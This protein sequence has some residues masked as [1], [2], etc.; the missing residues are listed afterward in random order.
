[1]SDTQPELSIIIVNWNGGQSL[2][3]CVQSVV[4][5][6]LE[7]TFD[8][9]V[10][11]N[12]SEDDSITQLLSSGKEL[13][14]R[15]I[16]NEE[17]RGFGAACNQGFAVTSSPYVFLLNPDAEV[18]PTSIG[19][20]LESLKKSPGVGAVG[21]R[22]L[23]SDGSVQASVF[24][25]PPNALHT[26]LWQLKLY[27]LL[28]KR[29]RGEL[30]LGRHWKH[31]RKR[32]VPMLT[33]AAIMIRREVIDQVGGFNEEF[34]MYGEDNEWCW[35]IKKAG[36]ELLFEPQAVVRHQG[37]QS[38]ARRWTPEEKLRVQLEAGFKFEQAA[39]SRRK[40]IANRL[41]NYLVVSTQVWFRELINER[42]PTLELVK[43]IQREL[44]QRSLKK[45]STT[46]R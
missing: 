38:A 40:L 14:L 37:G 24:V 2:V 34:H 39:L 31:N 35:R 19:T 32:R 11:D 3:E 33:G 26:V 10:V 27:H 4:D 46:S 43:E 28:P 45:V 17:N 13:Q 41:A 20:L 12:A 29:L 6:K 22:L 1:M 36:W 9:V 16:R 5:S 44:W 7:T 42:E 23:N 30:L 21:P 8:A 15:V 25:N 18:E